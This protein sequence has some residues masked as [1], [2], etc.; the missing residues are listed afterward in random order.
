MCIR[1]S[2]EVRIYSDIV[3]DPPVEV[4][5]QGV[6]VLQEFAPDVVIAFGGGSALDAAKAIRH[7]AK[8]LDGHQTEF[9]AI[10]T[11]SGTGSEVTSFAVI[12]DREKGVKY[13]LVSEALLPDMAILDSALVRTVP[14]PIVA[15]TG[16][17]VLTHAL[18]AYV[19]TCLL[20]TSRC[21]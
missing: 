13:P 16:M 17:D 14:R 6:K 12:T 18:E 9:V 7:F 1:D 10:P 4:V 3:P 5:V 21:V 2:N 15:D 11:T 20:Y 19:S 8:E